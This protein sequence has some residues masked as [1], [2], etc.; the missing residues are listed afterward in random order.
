MSVG[1]S[2]PAIRA[3]LWMVGT[4]VSFMA[5]ALGGREASAELSTFQILFFRSVVGLVVISALLAR[6]GW[7][8]ARTRR[9]GLQIVRNVAHFGG[10]YGWFY[11]IALIPLAEV[12]AIEF[13]VPI[14]TAI[15]ATLFLGERL[16]GGRVLAIVLGFAGILVIL[17]PGLAIV[18]TASLAVLAGAVGYATSHTITKKLSAT[19]TPLAIL[20]YMTVVQLPLALVPALGD[21]AWPSMAVWPWI[22]AVGVTALSA[23]YC[24]TR[25]FMLAEAT[26]V[27]PLDFLRLPLIAVVGFLAY[28]E[29][30]DFW[31]LGGAAVVF[32]GTYMNLRSARP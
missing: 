8:Q 26:V 14:W 23:H 15:L 17:R 25:A 10:Q 32:A 29:A 18:S 12:F 13:T 19:D 3:A 16:S 24:M 9:L 30:L 1:G 7:W 4:L 5:M 28:G 11:G 21:W 22:G 31:V 6:A 20:F 2:A 27:V